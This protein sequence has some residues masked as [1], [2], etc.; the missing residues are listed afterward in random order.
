MFGCQQPRGSLADPFNP[1]QAADSEVQEG[2]DDVSHARLTASGLANITFCSQFDGQESEFLQA[3]DAIISNDDTNDAAGESSQAEPPSQGPRRS[4]RVTRPTQKVIESQLEPPTVHVEES[5]ATSR[6]VVLLVRE[7]FHDA[8]NAFGLSRTYKGK[9][10]SIPDRP[11]SCT[12][13]PTYQHPTP[14]EESRTTEEIIRPY[15]NLSSFLFDHQ[16]WTSGPTKSRRDRD[17]MQA[18]L[19][20]DDFNAHDLKGVNFHAL[21]QE[22]RGR[23]SRGQWEQT[24]GWQTTDIGI[25]I[26]KGVKRTAAV[27]RE[28]VARDA[29]QRRGAPGP[30]PSKSAPIPGFQVSIPGFWHRSLCEVIQE[31]FSQDPA[32]RLFHY[33]PFKQTYSSPLDPTRP[34]DRV[35]DEVFT[36]DAWLK[37]DARVQMARID[38]SKP[39]QDLP[40]VIA[41]MMFWSDET[42]LNP[43]GQNKAWPVYLFFGNQPKSERAKHTAGGGRHVAYLPQVF[44]HSVVTSLLRISCFQQLPDRI[45]DKI[46]KAIGK[47][48]SNALLTHCRREIFQAAWLIL[49]QDPEFLDAYVNGMIVDCIDGIR[50]RV[51]PRFFTYSA[52]YPEKYV[53]FF[54][55]RKSP[56]LKV[57][58][59]LIATIK[60]FGA[61]PCPRCRVSINEIQAIGR[62]DDRKRREETRRR[63]DIERRKKVDEARKSLYDEG[64]AINGDHVDGLLKS[65]SL[66]PTKVPVFPVFSFPRALSRSSRMHSRWHFPHLALIF[67]PC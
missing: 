6:R 19:T 52:D 25:G 62:E 55:S 9:P 1:P 57:C 14:P 5:P 2:L 32:A 53:C 42:V 7:T 46:K 12:Y 65:E 21:E 38:P 22:L 24:R 59:T 67:M 44:F 23:S 34:I 56:V 15:P 45:E 11:N 26:P 41:A 20:R 16:F 35:Y 64:Y 3:L 61:C 33:H 40:R 27:R 51:F 18:M 47:A 63:D 10:S 48:A 50:R 37:E 66:V 54:A 36:S 60:D 58:R 17:S 49:I 39:E 13:I 4:G 31:T 29:R 8:Q 28:E 43:F 30:P